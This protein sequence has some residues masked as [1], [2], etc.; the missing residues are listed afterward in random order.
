MITLESADEATHTPPDARPPQTSAAQRTREGRPTVIILERDGSLHHYPPERTST[1]WRQARIA[2][3]KDQAQP[4]ILDRILDFTF[5]VLGI[6]NLEVRVY[7]HA[8]R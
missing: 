4:K 8:K 1:A 5:D 2:L 6:N 3:H 7:E